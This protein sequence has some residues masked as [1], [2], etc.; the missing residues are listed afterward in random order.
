MLFQDVDTQVQ[1]MVT[2]IMG[3]YPKIVAEGGQ[4]NMADPFVIAFAKCNNFIVVSGE[5]KQGN[6]NKPTIPFL[7]KEF[8]VKHMNILELIRHEGWLF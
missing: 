3:K 8:N 7:C 1:E 6:E 2:T 5:T 4:K